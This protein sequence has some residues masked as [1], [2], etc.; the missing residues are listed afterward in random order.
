MQPFVFRS[1]TRSASMDSLCRATSL[2][3]MICADMENLSNR[4]REGGIMAFFAVLFIIASV[5]GGVEMC[6]RR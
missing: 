5:R 4:K 1:A 3:S 6:G 2:P